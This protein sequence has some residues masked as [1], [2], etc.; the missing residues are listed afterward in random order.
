[1]I[2]QIPKILIALSVFF[3][4]GQAAADDS[5]AVHPEPRT[6]TVEVTGANPAER[7]RLLGELRLNPGSRL[8]EQAISTALERIVRFHA[9][10]GYP[11]CSARLTGLDTGSD[12][13]TDLRFTVERGL[14]VRLGEVRITGK[15]TR[16]TVLNRIAGI[17]SGAP[18]SERELAKATQRLAAS[19]LF[20]R[21]DSLRVTR[22][23]TR[24]L[25]D[26]D[27]ALEEFPG[28]RIEAAIG[29]G[30]AQ[31]RG[32]AGLVNLR[33]NNLFGSARSAS[34]RWQRPASNWQSLELS[35]REP[36][37]A[38]FPLALIVSFAQQVRDSLFSQT[39][40]EVLL[41]S[42]MSDGFSAGAGA[43]YSRAS[44][45][46]ESW[47]EAESS[48]LISLTGRV[49]WSSLTAP[50]NPSNGALI[51][52]TGSVGRRR[53][54]SVN[55]REIRS[56]VRAQAYIPL[57]SAAHVAAFRAG[58]SVVSRAE[59]TPEDIPWHARIPVGGTLAGGARV[60]GHAEETTRAS[61]ALWLGLEYRLLTGEF[62]RLFAFYDFAAARVADMQSGRWRTNGFHGLG[63]GI[64]ADTRLGLLEIALALNPE[65]GPGDGRLHIRLVES[66]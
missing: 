42:A 58:V 17:T 35:Y 5:T 21:V 66:F 60:R 27:L 33:M 11:F 65:R 14:F 49:S 23:R 7:S 61:R 20:R 53:I 63:A 59:S 4:T 13:R 54:E 50:V 19:G 62:S 18:Y 30:G 64:Q 51:E 38:G 9:S 12:G 52:A 8:D 45:G 44:P 48:R 6:G 31:G 34:F 47:S 39:G 41:E 36:W 16:E 40:A 55:H 28:I 22:G 37:L 2:K 56:V 46:S 57:G 15:R 26:I 10:R 32:L 3:A 1:M 25:A 29:G 43:A 24:S